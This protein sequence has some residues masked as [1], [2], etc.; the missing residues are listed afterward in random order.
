MR[1]TVRMYFQYTN[2]SLNDRPVEL[3]SEVLTDEEAH[4]FAQG[5][6]DL[7]GANAYVRHAFSENEYVVFGTFNSNVVSYYND[8]MMQFEFSERFFIEPREEGNPMKKKIIWIVGVILFII[9]LV[10]LWNTAAGDHGVLL[11]WLSIAGLIIWGL[12]IIGVGISL[13]WE[14]T[15]DYV[16]PPKPK[17]AK[18]GSVDG[19]KVA[20]TTLKVAAFPLT[21][22]FGYGAWRHK[23]KQNKSKEFWRGFRPWY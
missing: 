20:G 23:R 11:K 6:K 2:G 1:E 16:P 13:T 17:K 4:C 22:I 15:P 19:V 21:M 9:P 7:L 14:Y 12:T 5:L 18:K 8:K 3:V 10:L